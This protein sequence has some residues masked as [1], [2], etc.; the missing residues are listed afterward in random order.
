MQSRLV[1]CAILI[2]VIAILLAP[3][4]LLAQTSGIRGGNW[5]MAGDNFQ[6]G[7]LYPS[8]LTSG[9]TTTQA[10]S[11][12]TAVGKAFLN[13]Q[14]TIVRMPVNPPTVS[15]PNWWPQYQA[16]V[17]A[18]IADGLNVDL[19]YWVENGGGTIYNTTTWNQ[20][21]STINS[22]YGSNP[23]VYFEPI[24]EPYGYSAS[25][26]DSV[27]ENFL[28]TYKCPNWKCFF[29]GT[30][31]AQYLWG[32]ATDAKLDNQYFAVHIY[33]QWD[34]NNGGASNNPASYMPVLKSAI[35]GYDKQTVITEMGVA[36]GEND[37]YMRSGNLSAWVAYLNGVCNYMNSTNMGSIAW[38]GLMDNNGYSWYP[39]SSNVIAGNLTLTD[40]SVVQEFQYGWGLYP[41]TSVPGI[42]EYP[43]ATASSGQTTL[44]WTA[45]QGGAT[46]YN[47]Y[48]GTSSLGEGSTPITTGLTGT[49]YID[50]SVVDDTT[51]YYTIEAVNANGTSPGSLEVSAT[52]VG[53]AN[54]ANGVYQLTP[55]CSTG[56][57]LDANGWGTTNGTNVQIWAA[58]GGSNQKWTFTNMGN[59]WYKIQPSYSTTLSLE[60]SGQGTTNGSNVDLWADWGGANQRWGVYTLSNG[61]WLAP[62]N[63]PSMAL[64]VNGAGTANG[65][66]VQIWQFGPTDSASLWTIQSQGGAPV[67][68]S[69][70]TATGG[71]GQ[72]FLS[73]S[74][75]SGA[76]SYNVYRGTTA[77]GES[78]TPIATGITTTS[79]TN[80]GLSNGTTYYYTVKAVNGS[81]TSSAS[82]EANAVPVIPNGTYQLTPQCATGSRL[83]A[84]GWGTTNGTNVEIWAATGGTNQKWTFTNTGGGWFKIQPS[85]ST[86]LTLEVNGAGTTNGSTVGLWAD[87]GQAN[88]RWS[89]NAVNGGYE[90][91]PEH[92]AGQSLNVNGGGSADGTQ[93]VTWQYSG[94][95]GSIWTV[96]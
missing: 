18:L 2:A 4:R 9:M 1:L 22:V 24:N 87:Y 96:Q 82:Y 44:S 59:G 43:T 73:W 30:S 37:F 28:T 86:T 20:M 21:W 64:N 53:P 85:Y 61:F 3:E 66:N 74:A 5:A 39:S 15:D 42:P 16:A 46:S 36:G 76:T 72:A 55:N 17:N 93:I 67:P 27:Y 54:L 65:T 48:R 47:V 34:G 26:L 25:S 62:E 12:G 84:S 83:D 50:T 52:P 88:E 23:H 49:S 60:V 78:G 19:A 70:L 33:Q 29:D 32:V 11:V 41:S 45:N 94:Q 89:V 92:A 35:A 6:T 38:I 81:G 7:D 40:P 8:G 71:N 69:N 77:G 68:P 80:T 51:Y 58:T 79:Y 95:S 10:A 90:L 56:S 13:V 91:T 75:S 57:R 63:A 14:A 31:Y